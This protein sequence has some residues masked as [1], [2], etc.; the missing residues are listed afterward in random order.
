MCSINQVD[1]ADTGGENQ[2]KREKL[3]SEQVDYQATGTFT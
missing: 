1:V 3:D 2:C